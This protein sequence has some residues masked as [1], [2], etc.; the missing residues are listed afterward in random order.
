MKKTASI[1][2]LTLLL[3]QTGGILLIYK[4]Q[5]CYVWYEMQHTLNDSNTRFQKLELSLSDFQKSKINSD[6]IFFQGKMYDV[7]SV[8]VSGNIVNLL[9]INDKDEDS[10]LKKIDNFLNTT[11]KDNSKLPYQLQQLLSLNYLSPYSV[12]FFFIPSLSITTFHS[13]NLNLISNDSDTSSPPPES[14]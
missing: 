4:T 1:L 12:N 10:I 7:K 6:E 11:Q 5:Q 14:V 2:L 13:L 3:L 8:Q 9:V